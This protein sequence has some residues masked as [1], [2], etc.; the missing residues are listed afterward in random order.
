[1]GLDRIGAFRIHF[2]VMPGSFVVRVLTVSGWLACL[3]ATQ[4][5]GGFAAAPSIVRQPDDAKVTPRASVTFRV[6]ATGTAPLRYQWR[7][8]GA[9]LAEATQ[10]SLTIGNATAAWVGGYDVVIRNTT[11]S[12]TSRVARL[13]VRLPGEA[14]QL[15]EPPGPSSR[16]TGLVITEIHHQ[17]A[18]RNDGRQTAF[19]ELYH[20]NPFFEDLSGWRL[21]GWMNFTFPAGSRI[22]GQ[23][24]QVIA[25]SPHDL[26]ALHGIT[27]AL[28][29]QVP[30]AA[31]ASQTRT[32][33]L[34]KRSG[35]LVL[36]VA[37]ADRDPWPAASFGTGHSMVL[38]RPSLGEGNPLAWSPSARL[39]GSPGTADPPPDDSP[40]QVVFGEFLAATAPSSEPFLELFNRAFASIDLTGARIVEPSSGLSVPLAADTRCGARAYH[41]LRA[42]PSASLPVRGT[43]ALMHP[44]GTR[45]L[46]AFR[47]ELPEAGRALG[48]D[49]RERQPWRRL[50]VPTPGAPNAPRLQPE[51]LLNEILFHPPS[52]RDDDEFVELHNPGLEPIDLSGWRL[53]EGID[54]RFPDR[55]LLPPGGYR[56]VVP[57]VTRFLEVHPS[58]P[59]AHVLGNYD[60]RLSDAG[61][62]IALVRP[63]SPRTTTAETSWSVVDEVH[64]L[65]GGEWGRWSDGGGSSLEAVDPRADRREA[66]TWA[67]SDESKRAPWTMIESTGVLG[68]SH[69]GVPRADQLQVLLLGPGEALLD[70]VE[71]RVNGENRIANSTFRNGINGW[72]AQGTHRTTRW[73]SSEGFDDGASLRLVASDRGDHVANRVRVALTA[74][75]P[76]GTTVTL[77]ARIR[78][79][80]GHPE[81]LLRLRN[82]TLEASGRLD[83]PPYA[84]T[85]AAPNSRSRGNAPPSIAQV[86]HQPTL[87]A[88][89][90]PVRITARILDPDGVAEA[91]VRYRTDPQSLWNDV[92]MVDDGTGPDDVAH[93]GVFTAE[94]PGKPAGTLVAF[95]LSAT[96]SASADLGGPATATYPAQAPD[97]EA[98]VRF[99]ESTLAGTFGTYRLWMTRAAHDRWAAREKMS[100]EDVPVTFVVGSTRAIHGAGAHYSGSSYTAPIYNT[101]TGNLC[102]YNVRLPET[103]AFLGATQLTLDWPIRDNTNQR[104]QLMYWF[105]EELGLPNMYRRYVHLVVNGLRRGTI[106]DDVEQ[107]N[108]DTVHAWFAPDDEGSLW[109]TDCWNEFDDAGNRIDPCVLNTLQRF[110]SSGPPKIAR[111]RWNWRPRA[112]RGSANDF[113]DLLDLVEVVN[114]T[115]NYL[116]AVERAIDV[117]HWMRTFAMNDLASFWDAFGN[118]NAKNTFLYKPQRDRW[119]LM[120]W[121]FDVGLGVFN[122][123]TDAPLFDVGDPTLQKLYR[124]PALVRRYWAALEEALD[125]FFQVGAGT[126]IDARLDARYAAFQ[127]QNIP[128]SAPT[129]IKSWIRNRR[130]FLLAQLQT[131]RAPFAVTTPTSTHLLTSQPILD[132]AGTAPVGVRWLRVGDILPEVSWSTVTRWSTRI[133]LRPGTNTLR[134]TGLDRQQQPVPGAD[135]TLTIVFTGSPDQ[136]PA[137]RLNEW[138]A[139]NRTTL[140]DPADGDFDDWFEI[141][142]ADTRAV[143]LTGFSLTDD[144]ADPR[145]FVITTGPVLAP[146]AF[147]LV[148]ADGE[149]DQTS[150]FAGL[151]T[152]FRLDRSGS[153]LAIFDPLGRWVDSVR[154]G[155][156]ET[157]VSE[158][159]WPDG[160][161]LA[162]LRTTR[163]TPGAPNPEPPAIPLELAAR[164]YD[165]SGTRQV[166]I[167]WPATPGGRYIIEIRDGWSVDEAW[168]RPYPDLV[169]QGPQ[170]VFRLPVPTDG[171]VTEARYLRVRRAGSP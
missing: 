137:L 96:D 37:F 7:L 60:G 69:P 155:P 95:R 23:A 132:L 75:I 45:A 106:Y 26:A 165:E 99:G 33:R 94:L 100:N 20:S 117:D 28:P 16:R 30:P 63:V 42:F 130:T 27:T 66:A 51:V 157:D 143:D 64:Y 169:A 119:K 73:D 18:A 5:S 39:G 107:P 134:I 67:D 74:S 152:N 120:S 118:P 127:S 83:L 62:H 86:R 59:A 47:Y 17:P 13:V 101:P 92:L 78:W 170:A 93:D 111:Y 84:G 139:A 140:A 72:V 21:E 58:T 61:E 126:A 123:P 138:M 79:L 41:V 76:N 122:D 166:E 164:L 113:S 158:G 38:A 156:Q 24:Y 87:P 148:W 133:P 53:A 3:V 2:G 167:T 8:D 15:H 14:E 162:I 153:A 144:P 10:P 44:D 52:R 110:P 103:D 32:V 125:S 114:T 102:G 109:K 71:V 40:E 81:V 88:A 85:P 135:R 68:L 46:D 146:G 98:L 12:V 163:P 4:V 171:P 1:M 97:S 50:Q 43:L 149:P 108:R 145:R 9:P 35:A 56:V 90:Q 19:V 128:L 57:D 151:H 129:A 22:A 48:R 136:P 89:Q 104:E 142:N 6:E 115:S 77:R 161:A 150:A 80:R 141:Y 82:G 91:R 55:T 36:E 168:S 70:D 131:V 105:L 65:D 116:G 112:V 49:P 121:D 54:F 147:C 31:A 159:R 25:V 160:N 11:G 29:G 34:R 124:T 154:F